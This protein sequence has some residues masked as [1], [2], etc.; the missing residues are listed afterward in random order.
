MLE[1]R[2]ESWEWAWGQGY[3]CPPIYYELKSTTI[4]LL[5]GQFW[6]NIIMLILLVYQY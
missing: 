4:F 3:A 2:I 6:E 1:C 5:P